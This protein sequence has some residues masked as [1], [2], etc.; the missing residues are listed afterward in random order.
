MEPSTYPNAVKDCHS[1]SLAVKIVTFNW[2]S[3]IEL[4][5]FISHH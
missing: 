1:P 2:K 5:V 4:S 3:L